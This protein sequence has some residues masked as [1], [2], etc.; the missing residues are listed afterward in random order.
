MLIIIVSFAILLMPLSALAEGE[1]L[2]T[3]DNAN[4]YSGMDKAYKD[5]YL[6]KI[7]NGCAKIV[8]PLV[9]QDLNIKNNTIF[10]TPNFGDPATSPFVFSNIEQTVQRADNP[11]NNGAKPSCLVSL[12]LPLTDG[13]INGRYP[14]VI[15]AKYQKEDGTALEQSFTVYVTITDGKEA[16]S[17]APSEKPKPQPKI[18]IKDYKVSPDPV[19]AGQEFL[20]SFVLENTNTKQNVQNIKVMIKGETADL[21]P[22]AN[23]NTVWIKSIAKGKM[24]TIEFRMKVRLDAEPKPQKIQVAVEY[25]DSKATAITA[26]EEIPVEIK[27]PNRISFDPPNIKKT[28]N[29]GDKPCPSM[30][31]IWVKTSFPMS[32]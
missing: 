11:T 9:T 31:T 6:P 28:M 13:R 15:Q 19:V 18:I 2:L 8:L 24:H 12:S 3:I 14:V 7:E 10:V 5:G 16:A 4:I 29:A 22:A 17:A 20:L 23:S 30:Y 21:M 27:Q 26:N 1:A 32:C 25:E